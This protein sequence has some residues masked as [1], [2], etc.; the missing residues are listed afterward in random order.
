[1]PRDRLLLPQK[2]ASV[3]DGQEPHKLE[4]QVPGG[5]T[6]LWPVDMLFDRIGQM[7]L[8]TGWKQFTHAHEIEAGHF[9]IFKYDGNGVLVVIVFDETMCWR[10]YHNDDD[11]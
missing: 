2:S 5:N 7:Y 9:L 6:G 8:Y 11:E 1:M 3:L 4:L 10:H